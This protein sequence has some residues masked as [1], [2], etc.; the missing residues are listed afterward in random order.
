[1]SL[2]SATFK[3]EILGPTA[4][5]RRTDYLA[6]AE[7]EFRQEAVLPASYS[8]TTESKITRIV[9]TILSILIFP[10]GLCHLIHA[11]VG[12]LFILPASVPEMNELPYNYAHLERQKINFHED[13]WKYKR[14]TLEVNGCQIDAA[15]M[16]KAS[17][18]DQGRW[19][20]YSNGNLQ[21]YEEKLP[22]KQFKRILSNLNSNALVFNYPSV[23]ASSGL[24]NKKIMEKA[25]R[26]MLKLLEDKQNGMGAKEIIG[27]GHSIG[28]GVQGSAL[29]G[30]QLKQD[31]KYVFVKS[32]TFSSINDFASKI[33]PASLK[34]F[35]GAT[36]SCGWNFDSVESSKA[37]KV[38]EIIIQAAK[39][40]GYKILTD[41]RAIAHD[42]IIP[43]D[44]SLAAALLDDPTCPKN[45]KRFIG[46]P[47]EHND[48]F[49]NPDFITGSIEDCLKL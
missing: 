45:H 46:T 4:F 9:K 48:E 30:Y 7:K 25:Y 44:A 15:I 21:F 10:I 28:A 18:F 27:W 32:R 1:M 13:E 24:P 37:L 26:A 41:S 16:G 17:S 31:V 8:V 2:Q 42:G 14:F 5:Y 35:I 49:T 38:P 23:G 40:P 34:W 20:L 39:V 19:L 11:F 22:C 43:K 36:G 6:K 29:K 33:L 3:S 12:R 47:E